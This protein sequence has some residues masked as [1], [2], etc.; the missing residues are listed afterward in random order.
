M[1]EE[2]II[3]NADKILVTEIGTVTTTT[4]ITEIIIIETAI[5]EILITTTAITEITIIETLKKGI[6]ILFC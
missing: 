1:A 6:K 5:T 4:A 3:S 2:A